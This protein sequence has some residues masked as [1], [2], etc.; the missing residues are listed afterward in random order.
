MT[1][2]GEIF[3]HYAILFTYVFNLC[4]ALPPL[5]LGCVLLLCIFTYVEVFN[6]MQ[7]SAVLP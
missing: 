1:F 6:P 7:C 2:S 5:I 4:V 3:I